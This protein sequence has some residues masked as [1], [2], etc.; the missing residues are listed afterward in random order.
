MKNKWV[1]G[2]SDISGL[3]L[4]ITLKT[5][6]ATA[7]GTNLI[8]LRGKYS[9]ETTAKWQSVLSTKPGEA[10]LQESSPLFQKEWHHD[11][12]TD[13]IFHLTEKTVSLEDRSQW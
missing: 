13:Y 10:V 7:H 3:L 12:P 11:R 2:Y 9:D 5:G 6:I 1:L 4:A 8:D